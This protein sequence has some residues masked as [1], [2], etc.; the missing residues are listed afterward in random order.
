MR[1]AAKL[2]PARPAQAA[3]GRTRTTDFILHGSVTANCSTV[4]SSLLAK[5]VLENAVQG[6][7]YLGGLSVAKAIIP[8]QRIGSS[9]RFVNKGGVGGILMGEAIYSPGGGQYRGNWIHVVNRF[10]GLKFQINGETHFGW[11][12]L[13]VKLALT[14]PVQALLS[15]YAYETEPNTP[16]IA[17]QEHGQDSAVPVEPRIKG[18]TGPGASLTVPA[19]TATGVA[20]DARAR[21]VRPDAVAARGRPRALA[22]CCRLVGW[23][24]GGGWRR[25]KIRDSPCSMAPRNRTAPLCAIPP[26]D[27][28]VIALDQSS[29]RMPAIVLRLD[30]GIFF[31]RRQDARTT[32]AHR[33]RPGAAE[34]L[35]SKT[36]RYTC[37]NRT[38]SLCDSR[39]LLVGLSMK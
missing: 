34:F 6:A 12:R 30:C 7:N 23:R 27:R 18:E 16:I 24:H 9:Q 29:V 26:E 4:F 2:G 10:L 17:G 39:L 5:P 38:A 3:A 35:E 14:K 37:S 36:R 22:V 19:R 20:R 1:P 15:G 32:I 25:L 11:A 13:S 33:A 28:L 31:G 8:G 21:G